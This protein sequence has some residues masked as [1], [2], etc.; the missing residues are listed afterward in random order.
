MNTVFN[1]E[2]ISANINVTTSIKEVTSFKSPNAKKS[3]VT[4]DGFPVSL[5][6]CAIETKGFDWWRH[7]SLQL[8]HD[9]F[10]AM[11]VPILFVA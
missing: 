11:S 4:H 8:D 1:K 10:T 9:Q 7:Y 6:F 3:F 2:K 5:F